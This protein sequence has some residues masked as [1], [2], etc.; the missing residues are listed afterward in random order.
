MS[1]L[2]FN[3][4][5]VEEQQLQPSPGLFSRVGELPRMLPGTLDFKARWSGAGSRALKN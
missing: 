5:G 3:A 1:A 2:A 4:G